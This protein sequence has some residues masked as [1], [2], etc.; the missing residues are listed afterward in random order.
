MNFIIK[1]IIVIIIPFKEYLNPLLFF[2]CFVIN[3]QIIPNMA[4]A[5]PATPVVEAAPVMTAIPD[6]VVQ[7]PVAEVA[8]T[9]AM[10]TLGN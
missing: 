4:P 5:A 8:T 7:Q 10:P 2:T 6:A 9:P 3:T 1:T